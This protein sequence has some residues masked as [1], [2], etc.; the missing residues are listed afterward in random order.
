VTGYLVFAVFLLL[1]GL[2]VASIIRYTRRLGRAA[3]QRG[4]TDPPAR[5]GPD[6]NGSGRDRPKG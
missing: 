6:A 4:R 5:P 2:L 3:R 1:F